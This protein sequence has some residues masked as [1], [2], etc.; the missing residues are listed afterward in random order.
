MAARHQDTLSIA[1]GGAAEPSR[2]LS[3]VMLT[4]RESRTWLS[5]RTL[6]ACL[7]LRLGHLMNDSTKFV[8]VHIPVF[9]LL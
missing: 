6:L 3:H 2:V 4:K 9:S 8:A 7:I 1:P 5:R